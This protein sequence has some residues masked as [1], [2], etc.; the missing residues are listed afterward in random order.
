MFVNEIY[1]DEI[2][3]VPLSAFF[4]RVTFVV[5]VLP[6]VN[7]LRGV[8]HLKM[9]LIEPEFASANVEVVYGGAGDVRV[10]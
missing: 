2:V 10:V 8:F 1:F 3:D 5:E 4:A 9:V 7:G 6:K